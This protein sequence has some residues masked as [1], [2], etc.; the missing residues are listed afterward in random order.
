MYAR[1]CFF[2]WTR[3]TNVHLY[4][5][6]AVYLTHTINTIFLLLHF[7]RRWMRRHCHF[8]LSS[9]S[10]AFF[11]RPMSVSRLVR[12]EVRDSN[13]FYLSERKEIEGERERE[14]R[15]GHRSWG[16]TK[17]TRRCLQLT[18]TAAL[19]TPQLELYLSIYLST[20]YHFLSLP[21]FCLSFLLFSWFHSWLID[22]SLDNDR[23]EAMKKKLKTTDGFLHRHFDRSVSAHTNILR[24]HR[25]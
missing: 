5:Y 25:H 12:D 20:I 11:F 13:H 3:W 1:V 9:S 8:F 22:R 7:L 10:F 24:G 15:E 2:C 21:L 18:W 6:A 16:S 4:T 23:V 17:W 14:E 19:K